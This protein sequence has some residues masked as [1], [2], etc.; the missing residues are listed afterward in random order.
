MTK[1]TISVD[2]HIG[3]LMVV[4]II[5]GISSGFP[6]ASQ[7]DFHD[8]ESMF[9]LSQIFSHVCHLSAK[10]DPSKEAYGWLTS[11]PLWPLRSSLVGKSPWLWEWE[12]LGLFIIWAGPSLLSIVLLLIFLSVCSQRMNSNCSPSC[13]GRGMGHPPPASN[14]L[15][16]S[17]Y[18]T[19]GRWK[20]VQTGSSSSF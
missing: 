1:R 17:L 18:S 8:S 10:M 16:I 4:W 19:T 13:G 2:R 11:L 3:I 9:C 15:Q 14:I 12:I 5:W 7:F 6:L 20:R